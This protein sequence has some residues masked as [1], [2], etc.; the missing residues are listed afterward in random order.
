MKR[1]F[2]ISALIIL[3]LSFSFNLLAQETMVS[4]RVT[5]EK[6]DP[7]T[8]ANVTVRGKAGG[9]RTDANGNFS[10]SVA[11]GQS[12]LISF[13]GFEPKEILYDGQ[14][15][16]SVQLNV[17]FSN[18]EEVVAVGYG[19]VTKKEV[20]GSV[21]TVKAKDFNKGDVNNP[22]A[23][24]QGKVP[25]LTITKV[26]GGDP[27]SGYQIQLRGLNTLS[28]GRGPLIIVDGIIG[29]NT[30]NMIDPNEIESIDV[31]K[32]GSAAAI[33]GT[34][35][36]NGV[37]LITTKR[38]D[39]GD[40][41]FE[42]NSFIS[43]EV[44]AEKQRYLSPNEYRDVLTEYYPD[45]L[46]LDKGDN[47][48]WFDQVTR[49]PVNQNLSFSASGGTRKINY[50]AGLYYKLDQG[51]VQRT[52]SRT[53]TPSLFISQTGA[54]DKLKVDYRLLYSF[55][56]REWANNGV[57]GQAAWRN[58]TEPVYDPTDVD[59]GGYYTVVS[60]SGYLNPVAM[61]NERVDN[62]DDQYFS[63]DINAAYTL[64]RGFKLTMH[65]SYN[66]RQNFAGM[67][68]TRFFPD[69]GMNG[70]AIAYTNYTNDVL[71]EPGVEY[72]KSFKGHSVQAIGGYSYFE[73]H[74]RQLLAQ[75]YNF[76]LDNF[77]YNNIGSG[78][79]L[80]DG[81][82][83]MSTVQNENKLIA[84]YGRV[85]YNFLDKYLLSASVRHEG[86]TRF[87]ANN[88]WGTFPAISAGWRVN[89]EDFMQDVK[90]V[91]ALKL[92]IGYGVTGNQ[93]IPNY[94]SLSRLSI[95][96][97]QM[98]YN[99]SWIN[100]YQPASNPNPNLKWEKKEEYNAGVDFSLFD[101]RL[102][103]SIDFYH[104][105]IS[106]LLWWYSVP[107]PPNV[108]N[109]M[110]ANVG[111]MQNQGLEIALTWDAVRSKNFNVNTSVNF[112]RNR[113]KLLSFSDKNAGYELQFLKINP[114]A[115]TWTEFVE[116]GM[117]LGNFMAPVFLGTDASG[118]AIY[119]DVDKNGSVNVESELDRRTVGNA[120]PKFELGW[121]SSLQYKNFDLSFF[122][123]GV[124]GHSLLNME[125]VFY[126]NWQPL[127][128]GRNILRSKLENH[129][130]YTGIPTYDS[131]FVEKASFVKL[132]NVSIGYNFKVG[133]GGN[134]LRVYGTGQNLLCI[135]DYSGADPERPI[136]EFNTNTAT[137][138]TENLNYYPF[139]K[140][141]SIG[142]NFKF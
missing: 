31:L 90:W 118:N 46:Y 133:K 43:T 92:R 79:A 67:Y 134:L 80:P 61:V 70:N 74:Y 104:R 115:T 68:Q 28:G 111:S 50:R 66:S 82:A 47:T 120:Y 121:A 102:S 98:Y 87:G 16:V 49:T 93:D 25:G 131:R 96:P 77:S 62:V 113:N 22:M 137:G 60:S 78:Y 125:R 21:V 114:A 112:S 86:S 81:L 19:T 128:N 71:F 124:F 11:K 139:T 94:L 55:V 51:I 95:S 58:P 110:Y 138:G 29:G 41:K 33:Y 126:E 1:L 122:F 75:N 44:K 54:N 6:N 101:N 105:K 106:D 73:N 39:I 9:A 65:T 103:G 127:L 59:H 14:P 8:G 141:F 132:N 30:L 117:P 116:E 99:G 42:V 130:D 36:T 5:D 45:R 26:G 85:M 35:A 83:D 52:S 88:K 108:Y 84:F 89:E 2:S 15:N 53:I 64:L 3:M 48:D 20:T 10:I 23:L 18:L 100:T 38:P 136:S 17:A 72:K 4:G 119:E 109:N 56:K 107:V 34:R 135:T 7:V 140:T 27:N 24:I 142:F 40:V 76:D 37:I 12:L 32:D 69:L 123:R 97:R 13:I 129:P 63:G 57:L 91:K